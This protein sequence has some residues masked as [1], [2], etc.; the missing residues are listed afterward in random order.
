MSSLTQILALTPVA[1][2]EDVVAVMQQIEEALSPTDGVACFNKLYLQ[3]TRN[4]LAAEQKGGFDS[5]PF[6]SALDVAFGN[7][8]FA[9]L[10]A[11]DAGGAG[12][13]PAWQPLFEARASKKIAPIQFALAGMNAHINRDL[14]VGLVQ[15]FTGQGIQMLAPSPQHD[16][17]ERVNDVL[18]T[19]EGEM[20]TSY[21]SGM[22][23]QLANTFSGAEDVVSQWSVCKARDVA[24]TNGEILFKLHNSLPFLEGDYIATLDRGFAFAG[25]LLLQPTAD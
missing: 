22:M 24:W 19:T 8:Y 16:D 10:Q 12:L 20:R 7:L 2:I 11:D 18:A 21:F 13:P 4:V 25:R 3:V 5:I 14:P 17:F 1:R 6:L 9:A 23:A 15:A